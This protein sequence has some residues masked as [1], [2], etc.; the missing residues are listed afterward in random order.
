MA[1]R[2]I[3]TM[4]IVMSIVIGI[5]ALCLVK[6]QDDDDSKEIKA[7][8][9]VN[10]RPRQK[11]GNSAKYR[12]VSRTSAKG[13]ELSTRDSSLAQL[14]LTI[15]R[16][17]PTQANDKTKELV[18]EEDEKPSEWTLERIEEGTWLAPGQRVRLSIE[19]LTRDGY[20]YV[21]HVRRSG[22]GFPDAEERGCELRESRTASLCSIHHWSIQNQTE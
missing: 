21:I 16:F 13:V 5:A 11:S 7:Q 1:V 14:G 17:R 20:L 3:G 4:L 10:S 8:V 22:P 9:F 18:V 19:S 12:R 2:K 6:A 15:W